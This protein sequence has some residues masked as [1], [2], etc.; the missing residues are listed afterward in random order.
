MIIQ[1]FVGIAALFLGILMFLEPL[2]GN[3]PWENPDVTIVVVCG[4]LI[5]ALGFW[6]S[7]DYLNNGDLDRKRRKYY[8]Y[9]SRRP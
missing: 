7:L 3:L 1:A 5:A 9:G 4:A 2:V 6:T 8:P